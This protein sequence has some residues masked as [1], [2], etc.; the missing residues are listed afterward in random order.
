MKSRGRGYGRSTVRRR[1][2]PV[3]AFAAL[4]PAALAGCGESLDTGPAVPPAT[5]VVTETVGADTPTPPAEAAAGNAVT[6][7]RVFASAGCSGC[8]TLQA[9][10]SRAGIGPNLD[11]RSPSLEVVMDVV[12]N[13]RGGMPPFKGQL[14]ERQIRDVATFVAESTGG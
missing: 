7:K 10:G 3:L 11:E 13:G 8:H 2:V 14:S 5:E 4:L 12:T 1:L 6:G 9:A